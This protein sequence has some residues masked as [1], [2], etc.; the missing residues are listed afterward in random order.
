MTNHHIVQLFCSTTL[1]SLASTCTYILIYLYI[2]TEWKY[3]LLALK[4]KQLIIQLYIIINF[5]K[6]N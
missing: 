5:L 4:L 2:Y 6:N 3:M 1:N